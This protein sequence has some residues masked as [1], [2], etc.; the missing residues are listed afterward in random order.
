MKR[1]FLLVLVFSLLLVGC[2]SPEADPTEG[3]SNGL[4][5][6]LTSTTFLADIAQNVA[7]DRVK[8]ESLLPFGV[9]PHSYQP[10]PSD[11]ARIADS[12]VL[13]LNGAEY[14][15]SLEALIDNAGGER[16][17]I[18]ASAGQFRM[19]RVMEIVPDK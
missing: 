11:A 15:H 7:G 4:P 12:T 3:V 16:L 9:D 2:A 6:V 10:K 19:P 14:E 8:V 13:I 1:L 5:V 18:E 17:L